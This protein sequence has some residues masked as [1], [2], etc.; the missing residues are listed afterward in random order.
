MAQ[1]EKRRFT[2]GIRKDKTL[3][4]NEMKIKIKKKKCY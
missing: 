1:N 2:K 4:K 3:K